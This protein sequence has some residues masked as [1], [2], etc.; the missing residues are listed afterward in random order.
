MKKN[1]VRG[2]VKFRLRAPENL[3]TAL[4]QRYL[5]SWITKKNYIFVVIL[6]PTQ[7]FIR[8]FG[9]HTFIRFRISTTN[10]IQKYSFTLSTKFFAWPFLNVSRHLLALDGQI[11]IFFINCS[12]IMRLHFTMLASYSE[13]RRLCRLSASESLNSSIELSHL[14][15]RTKIFSPG[16]CLAFG[17]FLWSRFLGN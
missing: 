3:K 12:E 5:N 2:S 1:L 8:T 13:R 10:A 7:S 15:V 11:P 17:E 6:N 4:V 14:L 16:N 9:F